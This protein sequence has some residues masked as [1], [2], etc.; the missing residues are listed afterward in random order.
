MARTT[1]FTGAIV[2]RMIGR[3]EV[4]VHGWLSP[5]KVVTGPLFERLVRELRGL[6]IEFSLTTQVAERL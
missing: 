3:G 6:G 4:Q 5:E 2:A 1:G